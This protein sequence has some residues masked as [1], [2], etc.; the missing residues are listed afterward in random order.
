MKMKRWISICIVLFISIICQAQ[1]IYVGNSTSY[2]NIVV[3][4]KNGY[5]Y[6]GDS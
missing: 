4:I 1:R 6:T 5:V 3:N 2:S